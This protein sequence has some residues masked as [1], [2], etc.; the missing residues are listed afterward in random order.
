MSGTTPRDGDP[1][2]SPVSMTDLLAATRAA[3]AVCTPPTSA[4][5]GTD[6]TGPAVPPHLDAPAAA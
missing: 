6:E 2:T 5:D 3:R 1:P 4:D